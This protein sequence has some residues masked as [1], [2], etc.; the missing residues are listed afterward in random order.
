MAEQ[1]PLGRWRGG[2]AGITEPGCPALALSR[3]RGQR[4]GWGSAVTLAA[5]CHHTAGGQTH[6]PGNLL[7]RW[8]QRGGGGAP[9][10][11]GYGRTGR[12][13]PW[14]E[15]P[16]RDAGQKRETIEESGGVAMVTGGGGVWGGLVVEPTTLV[17]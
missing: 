11:G 14:Q 2:G 9:C 6:R 12:G 5:R 17:S 8:A 7:A 10:Q 16:Q 4:S 13:K 15:A 1:Q 3:R